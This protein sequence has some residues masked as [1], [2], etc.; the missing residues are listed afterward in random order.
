M[1]PHGDAPDMHVRLF[2]TSDDSTMSPTCD[3]LPIKRSG[4]AASLVADGGEGMLPGG[5]H[6]SMD[7]VC[8]RSSWCSPVQSM[9]GGLGAFGWSKAGS[10]NACARNSRANRGSTC[11]FFFFMNSAEALLR[12]DVQKPKGRRGRE[13][14]HHHY[15]LF[16]IA[17]V[18]T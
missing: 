11:M 17:F 7:A 4:S 15:C 12:F 8:A 5:M 18:Q 10:A 3:M 2:I 13:S 6:A 16:F 9:L 14:V 1:T